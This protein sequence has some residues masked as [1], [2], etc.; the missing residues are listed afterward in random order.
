VKP[1]HLMFWFIVLTTPWA[2]L[3]ADPWGRL[4]TTPLQRAQ[5]DSGQTAPVKTDD[6]ASQS[7]QPAAIERI[8]LTGTLTSSRGTR[9]AWL[10]G[11]PVSQ[12]VRV[13][14]P[15]QVQ[16]STPA[17]GKHRL[18]KSGQLL[19]PQTGE[20]VEGYATPQVAPADAGAQTEAE[21]AQA[22]M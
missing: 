9:T 13:L 3:Q 14:G 22:P 6:E 21:S 1:L 11:K 10:N 16:L 15:G 8:R 5:L 2:T 20:I 17:A 7:P 4:F 18:L 12:G 19:Y